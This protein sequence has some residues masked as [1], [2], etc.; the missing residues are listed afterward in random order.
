VIRRLIDAHALEGGS[1]KD[2]PVAT[3]KVDWMAISPEFDSVND[4][5]NRIFLR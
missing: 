4:R 1:V 2:C 3:L 5:L